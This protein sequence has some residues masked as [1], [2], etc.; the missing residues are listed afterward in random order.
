VL[1]L[2]HVGPRWFA[3]PPLACLADAARAAEAR[4]RVRVAQHVDFLVAVVESPLSRTL[5][6]AEKGVKNSEFAV[7]D[8]GAI[9]LDA[10]CDDGVGPDR[11][12]AMLRDAPDLAG[13]DARIRRDGYRLG[14]HKAHRLRALEARGVRVGVVAPGLPI[15]AARAAGFSRFADRGQAAAWLREALGASSR[16]ALVEDAGHTVVEIA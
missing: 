2:Q 13:V 15:D 16:G 9:L 10:P 11:F 1:A 6:Q 4:W 5:Y 7:K 3:G 12:V 14:D 8:G